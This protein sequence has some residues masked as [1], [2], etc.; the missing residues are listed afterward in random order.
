MFNALANDSGWLDG[1]FD[2]R[3]NNCGDSHPNQT[4]NMTVGNW[5]ASE[6]DRVITEYETKYN[7]P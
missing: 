6:V 4:A 7:N 2:C 5:V 1:Q 3:N